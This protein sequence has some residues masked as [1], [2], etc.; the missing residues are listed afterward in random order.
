MT[1]E[2]VIHV[3]DCK[4]GT[5]AIQNALK[6]KA[7]SCPGRT[8]LYPA[9]LKHS[10]LARTLKEGVP[11]KRRAARWS[12][13][14][15]RISR[16][17]ADIA[18]IS[19]ENLEFVTPE[20]LKAAL[21]EFLPEHAES[22][23]IV[24]YVRPHADRI[25]SSY[26]QRIKGSNLSLTL[27]EYY[28]LTK[29]R[30]TFLYEP[31]TSRWK[32]VFGDNYILRPM[33]RDQ[34]FRRDVVQDFLSIVLKTRDFEM[35]R[36]SGRNES[37]CVEDLAVLREFHWMT[38]RMRLDPVALAT[39]SRALGRIMMEHPREKATRLAFPKALI[40]DLIQTYSEDAALMDERFFKGSPMTDALLAA[41]ERATDEPQSLDAADYFSAEE[42]A[43]IRG[44]ITLTANMYRRFPDRWN[45]FFRDLMVADL[46]RHELLNTRR[47]RDTALVME[48]P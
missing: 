44:W 2:L 15:R 18:V 41:G 6:S 14:A 23:R 43:M 17:D 30:R 13:V 38:E 46:K 32:Q 34:L 7:W 37:L 29:E 3:G 19:A 12:K 9:R 11:A 22:A 10:V 1:K 40:P 8:V 4:T 28:E 21:V 42:L 47:D 35:R 48:T 39:I 26:A 33:L 36:F 31:R 24:A 20:A 5:T 25:L 16:S 45:R 27:E